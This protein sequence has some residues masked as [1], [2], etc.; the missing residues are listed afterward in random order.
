MKKEEKKT[1]TPEENEDKKQ[2]DNLKL[3]HA[4]VLSSWSF[5]QLRTW[6]DVHAKL[7]VEKHDNR[8]VTFPELRVFLD[9]QKDDL[10]QH[11]K[12]KYEDRSKTLAELQKEDVVVDESGLHNTKDYGLQPSPN[13]SAFH[14]WFQ[15]KAI[16]EL[17]QK[18]IIEKKKG[19]LLLAPTGTGKT[20]IVGGLARRL[21]DV[22][23]AKGKT[24]GTVPYL[25]ITRTTVVEQAKRVLEN[26]YNLD[27]INQ[28]EV[29][30][31]EQLRSRAGQLWVKEKMQI[32]NG[33]EQVTW[34]WKKHINPCVVFFDESQA[35]KNQGS[36]Q[37]KIMQ[38]YSMLP[39]NNTIVHIS[40]TPFTR[41]CEAKTFAIS[42]KRPLEHLG[43]PS[44]S[45]LNEHTW[46][47]YAGIITG[48]GSDPEDYNEAAVERLMKDLDGYVVRV[49][50]VKPQFVAHNNVEMIEFQNDEER[51][52]YMSAIE[53]FEREKAKAKKAKDAGENADTSIWVAML[54]YTMAA[55]ICRAPLI[56]KRMYE[57]VT[58]RNLAAVCACK[59]KGTVIKIVQEL[60]EKY[61][62]PRSEI[63]LIWG[64]GQTQL[65]AKQIQKKK[66]KDAAKKLEDMGLSSDEII[67]DMDLEEVEDRE[68]QNIPEHL[69]LGPQ[70]LEDRQIE[71]DKFQSGKSLYACYTFKAGGVGLSLHHTD[72]FTKFKCRHKESGYAV[73]ED[74]P[75]VPVRQRRGYIPPT[76]NAI[77][78]VQGLGRLPRL[79]SL[80]DTYQT[81]LFYRG[82]IEEDIAQVT[83]Q[84]LRCLSKVVRQR[85]DW[86]DIILD[87]SKTITHINNT[88]DEIGD[89]EGELIDEG[90]TEE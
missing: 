11:I 52:F 60:N 9:K 33:E 46:P 87:R 57:D 14:Y 37:T 43:F 62:V 70:T 20:F 51:K 41:V 50:N 13:E 79:T 32:V 65:T 63:S 68:L 78:L 88:K 76:Y 77:E 16:A 73:E 84:K 59:F 89:I 55:E 80:S 26:F 12:K 28:L 18:I 29:I 83:S 34:E 21:E 10:E 40:A 8:E 64:G 49:R 2:R 81:L 86:Q 5:R 30:N 66:I 39:A 27:T 24:Y 4:G 36:T 1:L 67:A 15:K 75:K 47:V 38:A 71:I 48:L 69:R 25:Y 19:V 35:A 72:E 6:T 61:G 42:T 44:G 58:K 74:I 90:G 22:T 82:T 54:K 7:G 17:W 56:A 31:I 45:V 23:Y 53:R 85:E 3:M